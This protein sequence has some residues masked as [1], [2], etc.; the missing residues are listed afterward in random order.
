M[1]TTLANIANSGAQ[2]SDFPMSQQVTHRYYLG[3]YSLYQ[4]DLRRAEAHLAFAFRNC[5]APNRNPGENE[6]IYRNSRL[7]LIYLT[8][9][10]LCLGRFPSQQLLQMYDL[11]PY[12]APLMHAVRVGNLELLNKTLNSPD[13]MSWLV[14]KELFFLLKEKLAVLCWRSLIRKI[15][16]VSRSPSDT[17]LRVQLPSLLNVVQKLT[18][19]PTYDIGDVECIAASLLDQVCC[20]CQHHSLL[21]LL[22]SIFMAKKL[23]Q[24][25]HWT[26]HLGLYQ[27]VHTLC[28]KNSCPWKQESIPH[29]SL[30]LRDGRGII[31]SSS[32]IIK[33]FSIHLFLPIEHHSTSNISAR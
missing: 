28:E 22:S 30:R 24:M 14:K 8:A 2:L 3:R 13:L 29:D 16:I 17:Q 18:G 23:T 9:C 32:K 5:P 26:T 11:E 10:R 15:C 1:P 7:T 6:V 25:E 12:F 20:L 31:K 33:N 19:D 27:R 21:L 4:L